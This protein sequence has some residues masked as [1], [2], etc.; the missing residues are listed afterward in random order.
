MR[1]PQSQIS[2]NVKALLLMDNLV[3][4]KVKMGGL[5]TAIFVAILLSTA[6]CSVIS[7]QVRKE[8]EPPVVFKTLME[9]TGSYIGKIVIVGGYILE[10]KNLADE[11]SILILQAPYKKGRKITVAGTVVGLTAAKVEDCPNQ[12]LNLESR[13]MHLWPE[14]YYYP[15][16]YYPYGD[17]YPYYPRRL[18]PYD[19]TW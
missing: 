2:F 15:R 17:P 9:Q 18:F 1:N 6:S 5:R 3:D 10:A 12:C 11:T 4:G 8:A 16:G 14:Y 7:S 19:P 13:E